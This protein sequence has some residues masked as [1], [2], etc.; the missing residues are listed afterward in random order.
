MTGLA[1]RVQRAMAFQS[2]AAYVD[3]ESRLVLTD[4]HAQEVRSLAM[5]A[6]MAV[7]H[8]FGMAPVVSVDARG[9]D[10]L[11]LAGRIRRQL[12]DLVRRHGEPN[13]EARMI[14]A[15][16]REHFRANLAGLGPTSGGAGRFGAGGGT[17]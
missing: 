1:M 7:V 4:D 14:V 13:H 2:M 17:R 16:S 3:R 6:Q 10:S 5:A 15:G 8:L 9:I 11:E 12:K